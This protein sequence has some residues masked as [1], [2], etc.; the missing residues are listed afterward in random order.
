MGS[1]HLCEVNTLDDANAWPFHFFGRLPHDA[2]ANVGRRMSSLSLRT[3]FSGICAPSTALFVL[4][5]VWNQFIKPS[6]SLITAS[7]DLPTLVYVAAVE[8]ST[9]CQ[10]ELQCLHHP[11]G[12]LFSNIMDFAADATKTLYKDMVASGTLTWH[13]LHDLVLAPGAV[14]RSAYCAKA[15]AN[16]RHE[17]AWLS[18]GGHPRTDY[19]SQGSLKKEDGVTA[20]YFLGFGQRCSSW[21]YHM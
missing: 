20:V 19:S 11:P 15:K 9:E 7:A 13:K 1:N 18:V 3:A 10:H 17:W 4:M 2:A 16:V 6:A 14:Q 5:V 8:W 21:C 12:C